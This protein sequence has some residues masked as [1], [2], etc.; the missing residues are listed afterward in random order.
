MLVAKRLVIKGRVQRVWYRAW[1]VET[2]RRIGLVG[3]VRN[4]RDGSVEA[5]V[6]GIDAAI[7]RFIGQAWDGPPAAEVESIDVLEETVSDMRDFEQR[8]TD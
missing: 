5:V 8:S 6:Q 7:E 3:W 4:R 2:A 1:T